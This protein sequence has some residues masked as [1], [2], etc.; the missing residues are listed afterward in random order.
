[1]HVDTAE[2]QAIRAE[3]LEVKA[4]RRALVWREALIDELEIRA[5]RRGSGRGRA[6]RHAR[7]RNGRR[8]SLR[9]VVTGEA[10]T[11]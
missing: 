9:L 6:G 5:E 8:G 11:G 10:V 1:M 2:F 3:A 7:P 4:L